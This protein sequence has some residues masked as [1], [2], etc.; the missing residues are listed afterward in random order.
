MVVMDTEVKLAQ[1]KPY[2]G[3]VMGENKYGMWVF[4]TLAYVALVALTPFAPKEELAGFREGMSVSMFGLMLVASIAGGLGYLWYTDAVFSYKKWV[5][6]RDAKQGL[7]D[8]VRTDLRD[9][10]NARYGTTITEEQA[11]GF[12]YYGGERI[13]RR[14]DG[15][16]EYVRAWVKNLDRITDCVP[17]YSDDRE[18]RPVPDVNKLGLELM[19]VEVPAEPK[20]LVFS[21]D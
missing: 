8:W 2:F 6:G 12:L 19:M 3:A 15:G 1:P 17:F 7:M 16:V 4:I 9:Y 13:A 5:F 18:T 21:Q 14:H 10:L 20:V 11:I